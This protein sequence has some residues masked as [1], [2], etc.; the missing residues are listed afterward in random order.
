MSFKC[1]LFAPLQV[2]HEVKRKEREYEKLQGRLRDLLSEKS[3]EARVALE[4]VGRLRDS[5]RGHAK[6][7]D[8]AMYQACSVPRAPCARHA[9]GSYRNQATAL[10]LL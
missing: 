2:Q 1:C 3:R 4:A 6:K 10:L 5:A 9:D 7:S 8:Q